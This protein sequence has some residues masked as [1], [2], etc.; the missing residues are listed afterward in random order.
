MCVS[1]TLASSY[2]HTRLEFGILNLQ[3]RSILPHEATIK[4]AVKTYN[5]ESKLSRLC[6]AMT[7]NNYAKIYDDGGGGASIWLI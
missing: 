6:S 5:M 4:F 2:I 1:R 7:R 3:H